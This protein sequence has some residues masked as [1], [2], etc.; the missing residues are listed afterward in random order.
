[1]I[2]TLATNKKSHVTNIN[3]QL[4]KGTTMNFLKDGGNMMFLRSIKLSKRLEFNVM[5]KSENTFL[6]CNDSV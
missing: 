2:T 4:S 3:D 5:H 6:A 1:M